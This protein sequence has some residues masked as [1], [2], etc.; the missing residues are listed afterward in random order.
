[1]TFTEFINVFYELYESIDDEITPIKETLANI[2]ELLTRFTM[3][4]LDLNVNKE[5]NFAPEDYLIKSDDPN[6]ITFFHLL[7]TDD[8]YYQ[9]YISMKITN[10][11]HLLH[12]KNVLNYHQDNGKV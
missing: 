2:E 1:M 10:K 6:L 9:N 3:G 5:E 11:M 8:I 4:F 12:I 7:L